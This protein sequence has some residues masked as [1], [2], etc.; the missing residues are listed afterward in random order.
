MTPNREKNWCC[1][2]G[3]GL[4]AEDEFLELRLKS[5]EKK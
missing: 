2:G 4:V 1:G 5:G 3:G